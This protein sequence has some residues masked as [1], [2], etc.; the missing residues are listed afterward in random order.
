MT[1]QAYVYREPSS[2][3]RQVVFPYDPPTK[4]DLLTT[5]PKFARWWDPG[6]HCWWVLDAHEKMAIAVLKNRG[7]QVLVKNLSETQLVLERSTEGFGNVFEA[8]LQEVPVELRLTVYRH[9]S[10]ALHPDRG[11]STELMK[12]LNTA[13]DGLG[14]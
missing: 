12:Q 6:A 11:G 10:L 2:P 9:L 5:L 4:D 8:L 13:W 14:R 1:Q 7:Y 3:W